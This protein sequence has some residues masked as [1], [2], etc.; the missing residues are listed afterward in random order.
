VQF[1]PTAKD[2]YNH[3]EHGFAI[4][5]HKAQGATASRSYLLASDIMGDREWAYV[6][7]SRAK[8]TTHLY[9][10]TE[11]KQSLALRFSKSHQ[12]T[13]SLDYLQPSGKTAVKDALE[14][15]I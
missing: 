7:A 14:P 4:S 13:S 15:E 2:G 6:G 12:K 11:M 9:C 3:I 5:V 1:S 10:T 8:D